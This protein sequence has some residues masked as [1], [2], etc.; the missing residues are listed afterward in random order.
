MAK[1]TR[2]AQAIFLDVV[3]N[4]Q[5]WEHFLNTTQANC[6]PAQIDPKQWSKAA[7]VAEVEATIAAVHTVASALEPLQ[8]AVIINAGARIS[9]DQTKVLVPFADFFDRF[10]DIPNLLWYFEAWNST[11][12]LETALWMKD[13]GMPK[14]IHWFGGNDTMLPSQMA[15][16]LIA[17]GDHDYFSMSREW[18]DGGWNWHPLYAST[19]CGRPLS[20]ATGSGPDLPGRSQRS[21]WKREFEHCTVQLDL[22]CDIP[23][24]DG[25]GTIAPRAVAVAS[26]AVATATKPVKLIIGRAPTMAWVPNGTTA[27]RLLVVTSC[28]DYGICMS[29][30]TDLGRSW[31]TGNVTA[32]AGDAGE[33]RAHAPL[34][35]A[36]LPFSFD[37]GKGF[38]G[39]GSARRAP[40]VLH[41]QSAEL[42]TDSSH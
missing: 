13:R 1:A 27:G 15:A 26:A 18:T 36:G 11:L 35:M 14:V 21:V 8:K 12:D 29:T 7:S 41:A 6:T 25:C 31:D 23:S 9:D 10:D 42:L 40:R 39:L 28:E 38:F 17:Q 24:R 37:G 22:G 5:A 4:G 33:G 34:H 30:S 19:K 20:N 16:F 32:G 2:V 3:D